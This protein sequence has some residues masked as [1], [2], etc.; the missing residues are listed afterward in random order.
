M[1]GKD[2]EYIVLGGGLAGL[3]FTANIKS[4][5]VKIIERLDKPGGLVRSIQINNFWFDAVVHLLHFQHNDEKEKLSKYLSSE[6]SPILQNAN[7]YTKAGITKFPFQSNLG[8]L[9]REIAVKCVI[10]Y[11]DKIKSEPKILVNFKEWLVQSFGEKMCDIFFYPYNEKLWKTPLDSLATRDF[12]WTIQQF[13]LEK[14]IEG[15]IPNVTSNESYNLNSLYPIPK[16]NGSTRCMGVLKKYYYSKGCISTIPL[17]ELLNITTPKILESYELNSIGV[18][19][20]M[21][22]LNG[23]KYDSQVL[24]SY[25]ASS[26]YIFSRLIYMQ[27]F[28]PGTAPEGSWSLMAEITYNK[29]QTPNIENVESKVKEGLLKLN[30]VK[31]EQDFIDIHYEIHPYAYNIFENQTMD[32]VNRLRETYKSVGVHLLGRYGNWQYISM[33]Q[34]YAEALNMADQ[35]NRLD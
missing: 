21:V 17:P 2:L 25:F 33:S 30:I 14:V 18:I 22:M 11:I 1:K 12:T 13:N 4:N 28:D 24:S 5:K 34:G 20:A 31:N 7:V 35:F 27:N 16:K 32:S 19:Y 26:E 3:S 9:P 10:D 29:N 8:Q 6:F 15:L 23:E